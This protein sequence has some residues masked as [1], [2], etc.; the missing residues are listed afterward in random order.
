MGNGAQ[1]SPTHQNPEHQDA[2]GAILEGIA[3]VVEDKLGVKAK[4]LRRLYSGSWGRHGGKMLNNSKS[5]PKRTTLEDESNVG[6]HSG[7]AATIVAAA[8]NTIHESKAGRENAKDSST[9]SYSFP[10]P[11]ESPDKP[12]TPVTPFKPPRRRR[13][14]RLAVTRVLSNVVSW[15]AK[16]ADIV[17]KDQKK[18]K[19]KEKKQLRA[20]RNS[21]N[22]PAEL[23]HNNA[24]N[25]ENCD[26]N[27]AAAVAAA[28]AKNLE[29]SSSTSALTTDPTIMRL[30]ELD[31]NGGNLADILS[32]DE[33][34]DSSDDDDSTDSADSEIEDDDD[35]GDK[36]GTRM[37]SN[38]FKEVDIDGS[39]GLDFN[40]FAKFVA[41]I[42]IFFCG[43]CVS[44]L[45]AKPLILRSASSGLH[46]VFCSCSMIRSHPWAQQ[47][48]RLTLLKVF[49]SLDVDGNGF[50]S[51]IEFRDW[52]AE[53]QV[54]SC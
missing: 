36:L 8:S 21:L 22:T 42:F 39:G 34:D 15:E 35:D 32:D 30:R 20:R 31:R 50:I 24:A 16:A 17:E 29:R 37:F 48:N 44:V 45:R 14:S 6:L 23:P 3:S 10:E 7:D 46:V 38:F 53:F 47:I 4:K 40:E 41:C 11:V 52:F 49:K 9:E 1:T 28:K 43:L 13:H 26:S 19:K 12:S 5:K 25:D 54:V 51:E 33:S 2:A 27:N 18:K